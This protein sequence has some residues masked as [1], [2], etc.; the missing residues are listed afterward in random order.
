MV[1]SVGV[2]VTEC[3]AAPT[4]GAVLGVVKAKLPATLPAPLLS[5]ELASVCPE[6]IAV[7]VGRVV[8]VGV[9]FDTVTLTFVVTVV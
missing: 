7:A 3:V 4:A 5:V 8:I 9:A 1:E 6:V 2:N